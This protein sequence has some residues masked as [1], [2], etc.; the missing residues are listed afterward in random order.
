MNR[1]YFILSILTAGAGCSSGSETEDIIPPS[2]EPPIIEQE[3]VSAGINTE[4][5]AYGIV[6]LRIEPDEFPDLVPGIVLREFNADAGAI[7]QFI[8]LGQES[9]VG[10]IEFLYRLTP[11]TCR[12]SQRDNDAFS[13]VIPGINLY[14]LLANQLRISAD[15][16]IGESII[17]STD[18]GTLLESTRRRI[19]NITYYRND[20]DISDFS[21]PTGLSLDIPQSSDFPIFRSQIADLSG[22]ELTSPSFGEITQFNTQFEWEVVDG[23]NTFIRLL[24]YKP[25]GST[26]ILVDCYAE[27]DGNFVIPV[28]EL[29]F[30]DEENFNDFSFSVS[31]VSIQSRIQDDNLLLVMYHVGRR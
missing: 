29:D 11:D 8:Q 31:R 12:I 10:E 17:F 4:I 21:V 27:D 6:S 23:E 16:D 7:A 22:P 14:N 2:S 20:T 26:R 13:T 3:I 1:I 28:N 30:I 18:Q 19:N 25:V 24:A 15:L 9:T 5:N